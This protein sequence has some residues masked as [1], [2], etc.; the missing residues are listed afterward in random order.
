VGA[1]ALVERTLNE[2]GSLSLRDLGALTGLRDAMAAVCGLICDGAVEINL[3][4]KL[5]ENSVVAV[6]TGS[7]P[8]NSPQAERG[9][10]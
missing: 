5:D 6:A 2:H 10:L 1:K 7:V 3:K 4:Q 9:P 8:V